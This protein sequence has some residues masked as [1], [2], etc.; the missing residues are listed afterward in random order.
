M[1]KKDGVLLGYGLSCIKRLETSIEVI[2]SD[3]G[4]S[5]L[6]VISVIPEKDLSKFIKIITRSATWCRYPIIAVFTTIRTETNDGICVS[7]KS[8]I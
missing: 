4:D 2:E 3:I 7:I 5:F 6:V 1:A 8:M